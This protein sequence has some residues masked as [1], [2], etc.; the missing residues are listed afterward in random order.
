MVFFI[1]LFA[2]ILAYLQP[3]WARLWA[4]VGLCVPIA[5]VVIRPGLFVIEPHQAD[6]SWK[7]LAGIALVVLALGFAGSFLGARVRQA[8]ARPVAQ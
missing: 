4:F 8:L 7:S 5:H 2:F 1:L 6:L 3:A